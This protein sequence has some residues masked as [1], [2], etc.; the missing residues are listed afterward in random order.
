MENVVTEQK[1]R[2]KKKQLASQIL[3]R[4]LLRIEYVFVVET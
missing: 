3:F 1:K 2:R 4:K